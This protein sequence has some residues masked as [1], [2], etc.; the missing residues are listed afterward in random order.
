MDR[1]G[2]NY[3]SWQAIREPGVYRFYRPGYWQDW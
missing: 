3:G 2:P 1:H